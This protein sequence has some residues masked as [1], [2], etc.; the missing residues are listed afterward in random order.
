MVN[1]LLTW[2]SG[3]NPWRE[4]LIFFASS[5]LFAANLALG[6]KKRWGWVL[7][8]VGNG[9]WGLWGILY[10]SPVVLLESFVFQYAAW[11]GW[12]K[13]GKHEPGA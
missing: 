9:S 11:R 2:F 13:W 8:W 12:R 4:A 10:H 7:S 3:V 6:S 1:D 5:F